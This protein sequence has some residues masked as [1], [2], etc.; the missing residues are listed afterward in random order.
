MAVRVT[1]GE[2]QPVVVETMGTAEVG[3]VVPPPEIHVLVT[4]S[5]LVW[6][7]SLADAGE[8]FNPAL[9]ESCSRVTDL[10]I[11][12]AKYPDGP[13]EPMRLRVEIL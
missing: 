1:L 11:K 2:G 12:A 13:L 6:H 7:P 4:S 8:G 9:V 3:G 5:V 10:T